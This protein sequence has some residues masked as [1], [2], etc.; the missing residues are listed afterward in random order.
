[1]GP[2]WTRVST[3]LRRSAQE[4][5]E[6]EGE[7][8]SERADGARSERKEREWDK[9]DIGEKGRESSPR[10]ARSRPGWAGSV[11]TLKNLWPALRPTSKRCYSRVLGAGTVRFT[12]RRQ[13]RKEERAGEMEGEQKEIHER[14][15]VR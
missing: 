10:E 6:H 5:Q 15:R 7:G 8:Q 13:E 4:M 9:R 1:M 11:R 3:F 12:Q 14:E 2:D